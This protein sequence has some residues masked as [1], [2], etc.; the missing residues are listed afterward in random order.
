M[1]QNIIFVGPMGAGKTT[2]GKQLARE[3]GRPFFDSDQV[4]EE[5]TGANIPLIFELEGENGFRR[6]E[7]AMLQELLAKKNIVLA[8]GGGAVLDPDNRA[9]F[10]S[11]GFVIYLSVPLE[12]LVKRTAKD[13]NRPLLQDTDPRQKLQELITQREPLYREVADEIID[14]KDRVIR[15]IMKNLLKL[16]DEHGL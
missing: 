13:R 11:R 2:I 6:R 5:R 14:S 12:Q 9:L 3:L 7:K 1:T 16:V 8:T 4:I 10:A 15:N